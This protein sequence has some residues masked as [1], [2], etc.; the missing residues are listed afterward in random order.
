VF[1]LM[2]C[3]C[4]SSISSGYRL[5]GIML[6]CQIIPKTRGHSNV[7]PSLAKSGVLWFLCCACV[8]WCGVIVELS[9]IFQKLFLGVLIFLLFD[10]DLLLG[11]TLG[12]PIRLEIWWMIRSTI[13]TLFLIRECFISVVAVDGGL[14]VVVGGTDQL[15]CLDGSWVEDRTLRTA[16]RY[17]VATC[18]A[19]GLSPVRKCLPLRRTSYHPSPTPVEQP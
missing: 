9:Q 14:I 3:A 5:V 18:G 1:T 7:K 13:I 8:L 16:F 12:L 6:Y 11:G 10:L 2:M 4:S 19:S 17:D 15:C